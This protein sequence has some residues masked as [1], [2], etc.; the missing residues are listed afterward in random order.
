M[1]IVTVTAPL[2]LTNY[3]EDHRWHM[4]HLRRNSQTQPQRRRQFVFMYLPLASSYA[5]NLANRLQN[6]LLLMF[7]HPKE[8]NAKYLSDLTLSCPKVLSSRRT[9]VNI[10]L[11]ALLIQIFITTLK[12]VK[13]IFVIREQPNFFPVKCEMACNFFVNCDFIRSREP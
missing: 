4:S 7:L 13:R 5:Q 3:D 10:P 8:E 1:A 6:T 2:S 11:P 12:V 9:A